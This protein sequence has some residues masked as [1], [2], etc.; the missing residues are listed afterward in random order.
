MGFLSG[1]DGRD[2]RDGAPGRD[3]RGIA[4]TTITDDNELKI[5]YDDGT[6]EIAGQV[7][8]VRI[9]QEVVRQE[10]VIPTGTYINYLDT[11]LNR[12]RVQTLPLS[13]TSNT[14]N[15]KVVYSLYVDELNRGDVV[16]V[17]GEMQVTNDLPYVVSTVSALALCDDPY[18]TQDVTFIVPYNGRNVDRSI[19]HHNPIVKIGSFEAE[20]EMKNKYINWLC[21]AASDAS[22][23]SHSVRIDQG[24]GRMSAIIHRK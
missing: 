10:V 9:E 24:Y 4:S 15:A 19:V 11:G 17:F 23:P 3:G 12:E 8:T 20:H 18:Q 13:R 6:E 16:Q 22:S 1:D 2:G 14:L 5:I 7:P 21:F